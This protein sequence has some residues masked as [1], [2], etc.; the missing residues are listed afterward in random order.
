MPLDKPISMG[1]AAAAFEEVDATPLEGFEPEKVDEILGLK[2]KGLRSCVILTLGYRDEG[3]DWLVNLK[4]VRKSKED[5]V[6]I[7][8]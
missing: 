6:T 2:E 1:L 3:N 8:D 7:I 5:L 4:K